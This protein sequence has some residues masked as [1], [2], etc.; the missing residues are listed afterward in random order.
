MLHFV[1]PFSVSVKDILLAEVQLTLDAKTLT[2][3]FNFF[4][5]GLELVDLIPELSFF[6][7]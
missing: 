4:G 2:S 7:V 5:Y 1:D 3:L 6:L